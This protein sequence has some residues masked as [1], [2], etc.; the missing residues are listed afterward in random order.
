[1]L[2]QLVCS[3]RVVVDLSVFFTAHLLFYI[4]IYIYVYISNYN[5]PI[6]VHG[7]HIAAL[8]ALVHTISPLIVHARVEY[9]L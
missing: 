5:F 7:R 1:M 9:M 3:I 6:L 4:Y 8:I 2:Y